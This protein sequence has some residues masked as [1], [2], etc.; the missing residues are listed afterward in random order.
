MFSSPKGLHEPDAKDPP[1][2][3][4]RKV[5]LEGIFA[6]QE[7]DACR[8][9]AE[10]RLLLLCV[11]VC[12][13]LAAATWLTGGAGRYNI[14]NGVFA[15]DAITFNSAA[16]LLIKSDEASS[17]T[18]T[19]STTA[20][21][22]DRHTQ[23]PVSF[24][25]LFGCAEAYKQC[26]PSSPADCA[27]DA[28]ICPTGNSPSSLFQGGCPGSGAGI[29]AGWTFSVGGPASAVAVPEQAFN[30]GLISQK[31]VSACHV[32]PAAC[33]CFLLVICLGNCLLCRA[34]LR[35]CGFVLLT[36]TAHWRPVPLHHVCLLLLQTSFCYLRPQKDLDCHAS[37]TPNSAVVLGPALP[38][39]IPSTSQLQRAPLIPAMFPPHL[40]PGSA[41][42]RTHTMHSNV[43]AASVPVFGSSTPWT[44]ASFTC[45]L[46]CGT[47][48]PAGSPP[49]LRASLTPS[50]GTFRQ[51]GQPST[52]RLPC[53]TTDYSSAAA[54]T[55]ARCAGP[56]SSQVRCTA[57][58]RSTCPPTHTLRCSGQLAT[59]CSP[60]TRPPST[61]PHRAAAWPSFRP[62]SHSTC[63][64][65]RASPAAPGSRSAP[66]Y[67]PQTSRQRAQE[68]VTSGSQ[69]PGSM[70]A[71]CSLMRLGR[72][73]GNPSWDCSVVRQP[74]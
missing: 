29:E 45:V 74:A 13:I 11:C 44:D 72:C 15:K 54:L 52:P 2:R 19:D 67:S 35:A 12:P 63:A 66:T 47:R 14:N 40:A 18:T 5:F 51:H 7:C 26:T 46:S 23:Q 33:L 31:V 39:A 17:A 25:G 49:C 68:A 27:S 20:R 73:Q 22:A 38:R 50:S 48:A 56:T 30:A 32:V 43:Q 42:P 8:L 3:V 62:P 9:R 59:R 16:T 53:M 34:A 36:M 57:A 64:Q 58:C 71:S 28:S 69:G 55:S 1:S 60:S 4:T 37:I 24:K 61:S 10:L 21:H 6:C 70:G 65:G 41:V